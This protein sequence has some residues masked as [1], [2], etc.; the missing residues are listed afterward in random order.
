M[1]SKLCLPHE[2]MVWLWGTNR[3]YEFSCYL[4]VP[5]LL[6]SLTENMGRDFT[7]PGK[8]HSTMHVI[9]SLFSFNKE[10]TAG[11]CQ[12]GWEDWLRMCVPP[13]SK[14]PFI[15][16]PSLGPGLS[17]HRVTPRSH[18]AL[19]PSTSSSPS[20]LTTSLCS[21]N[22]GKWERQYS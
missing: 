7:P 17:G 3:S 14:V 10:R 11:H 22:F 1:W 2:E 21:G 13:I 4:T 12:W 16:Q 19:K 9:V 20:L 15:G 5:W 6:F 18:S 8:H